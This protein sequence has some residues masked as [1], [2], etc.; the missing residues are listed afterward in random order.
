MSFISFCTKS[1]VLLFNCQ[2]VLCS[3]V[4][5]MM[6]PVCNEVT[7]RILFL[8]LVQVQSKLQHVST[9][10]WLCYYEYYEWNVFSQSLIAPTI[11]Q[12][13]NVF[14]IQIMILLQL[15][16][17]VYFIKWM[18]Y[19]SNYGLKR[20]KVLVYELQF[21]NVKFLWKQEESKAQYY[22]FCFHLFV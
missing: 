8:P 6:K 12:T 13:R 1:S 2:D 15:C 14:L 21:P 17:R 10:L 20:E 9:W 18:Q 19:L 4:S 7:V 11:L 5:L 22:N 3:P 16:H